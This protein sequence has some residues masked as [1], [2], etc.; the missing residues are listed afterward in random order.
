VDGELAGL[1]VLE[2]GRV[3]LSVAVGE[4]EVER[5]TVGDLEREGVGESVEG[6]VG[7]G[8]CDVV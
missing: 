7:E 1:A 3:G 5:V 4:R 2:G 6:P 8:V